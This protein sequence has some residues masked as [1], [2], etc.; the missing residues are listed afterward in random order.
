[1]KF[2]KSLLLF[3]IIFGIYLYTG[4]PTIPPYRDSGDLITSSYTLGI[5]HPP[6][7]PVYSIFGKIFNLIFPLGNIA[8]RVNLMSIFFGALTCALLYYYFGLASSLF[9]S[10]CC[11][12]W[13]LSHVSE[14]YSMSAFFVVI[15]LIFFLN[16]KYILA[17]FVFGLGIG[18][19]PTLILLFPGIFLF[20]LENKSDFSGKLFLNCLLFFIIGLSV[21]LYLPLRSYQEPILNWGNPKNLRNFLRLVTRADYGGLKLHPEQSKFVWSLNSILQQSKL[22]VIATIE[23][24]T[25]I[26]LIL[27]IIGI[28]LSYRKKTLGLLLSGYLFTGVMFFILSNL[29]VDEK[30]TLPILEPHLVIPNLI[31]S[32]F[33]GYT[34]EEIRKYSRGK[35]IWLFI[36]VPL[37]LLV[38][39]FSEHNRRQHFFAYE[40]GKNVLFTMSNDSILFDPDDSTAFIVGY[41]RTCEKKRK[42]IKPVLYFR[43]RWGYEYL[44]K[45]YPEI[46]PEKDIPSAQELIRT[47][48]E[49]NLGKRDIYFDIATKVPEG[50]SSTTNGLL[51]KLET[52]KTKPSDFLFKNY[53]YRG[54]YNS[55]LYND[56]FT[57]RIFYYYSAGYNNLGLE[58]NRSGEKNKAKEC[59][60]IATFIKPD[61]TEA[62]NN[63]GTIYYSEGE[64]KTAIEY[65]KKALSFKEKDA[66]ILYNIGISYKQEHNIEKAEEYFRKAVKV[67][68]YL[69]AANE[70]GLIMLNR[71]DL[72]QAISIF[73]EITK[74]AP[75]YY[76]AYYNLGL[77]YQKK[78]E[79]SMA[80]ENFK[81]YLNFTND[82]EEKKEVQKI[83]DYLLR[84]L[85]L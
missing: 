1:M 66:M 22:F 76:F 2:Y 60:K 70:L 58:Y 51:Y 24:F 28:C 40:Y 38:R 26:G 63:L 73:E 32:I 21:F 83:I 62:W 78:G 8:Y 20:L 67:G 55:E 42:D 64:Y 56:F 72:Q 19:H 30:T 15:F 12:F 57:Q 35:F 80:I 77:A 53:I 29:P 48:F 25:F 52:E 79:Y 43:T 85:R 54:K 49:Y 17:S 46:L 16:R 27:G 41:L 39:N 9:L 13:A 6:G 50:Y 4:Y 44:K 74:K 69:P 11:A 81:K 14:M 36:L 47:I 59:L 33:I 3:L 82:P 68:G 7:Y 31:F 71:G 34:V 45:H 75:Q 37:F 10:F 65:F 18:V 5:A 23:Q 84:L 61:L